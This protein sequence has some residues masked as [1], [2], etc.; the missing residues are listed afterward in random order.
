MDKRTLISALLVLF[1]CFEASSQSNDVNIVRQF[2]NCLSNWASKSNSFSM[3]SLEW[4]CSKN[5]AFRV[6][7]NIMHRLADKNNIIKTDTYDLDV[8]VSCMQKEIDKGISITFSDIKTV[9]A[10]MISKSYKDVQYVSCNIKLSGASNY[11]GNDLFILKN[12]RIVKIQDYVVIVDK[13]GHRKIKVDFS[14]IDI[15]LEDTE[16]LGLSYY[17]SKAFP[18][19]ASLVYS[20]WKFMISID[21]GVNFDKDKYTTQKVDF[22]NVVNYKIKKGEYDLKTFFAVTP[23]FYM[24]YFS[25]GCGLGY[26]LLEGSVT[27]EENKLEVQPNGSVVQ[28][29]ITTTTSKEGLLKLVLR[30]SIK[31][32]IPC[33]DNLFIS[34]SVNYDWIKGYKDKSGISFGAG[35]HFLMD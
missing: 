28:N 18:V 15:D 10:A 31:G 26:A 24:K 20:K 30:P 11:N 25:I 12:G 3:E 13:K 22:T 27:S 19:G 23:A 34:L 17:Y 33:N 4:L 8:F 14:D 21:F 2:G 5:P 1:L 9:P 35:I 7:D 32:Y 6:G 16:G 29:T